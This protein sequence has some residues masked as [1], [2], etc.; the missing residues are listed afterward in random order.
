MYIDEFYSKR[1]LFITG[2]TGFLGKSLIEKLLRDCPGIKTMYMLIRPK[3]GKTAMERLVDYKNDPVFARLRR[4]QPSVLDK[5]VPIVG[6]CS[7]I[8]LGISQEDLN[9]LKNVSIIF[10][11]AAFVKFDNDLR[12]SILMNT[13]GTYELVKIAQTLKHLIAFIHCSTAYIY[14]FGHEIEE[15][16]YKLPTDWRTAIKLAET[17]DVETLEILRLKYTGFFPNPY[18]F[19]KNLAEQIIAD[20]SDVLPMTIL[21]PV[22][23]APAYMEPE[24]GY[25]DN[26]NGP[27]GI[28]AAVSLGVSQ[29]AY[30]NP[31]LNL[32]LIPVDLVTS[33]TIGSGFRCGMETLS[34]PKSSP[35]KLRIQT[36]A[37]GKMYDFTIQ[38]STK[39]IVELVKKNP[40]QNAVWAPSPRMTTNMYWYLIWLFLVHI[41]MAIIYDLI[42]VLAKRKPIL[43]KTTRRIIYTVRTLGKFS[44]KY[45]EFHNEGMWDLYYATMENDRDHRFYHVDAMNMDFH[46]IFDG[47]LKGLKKFILKE[48]EEATPAT[49]RRFQ[50]LLMAD[51]I[52]KIILFVVCV[53]WAWKWVHSFV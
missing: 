27:M 16:I 19:T 37:P 34:K 12:S 40:I 2:G 33:L 52:I 39:K 38:Q 26:L 29:M 25:F 10:H 18:S 17:Y 22:V 49:R 8:G 50:M 43:L 48:P 21:R 1:E 4:D 41:P 36:F 7:E 11:E 32:S 24:P 9:R 45:F 53:K 44:K 14:P 28:L 51:Q 42:F 13:R 31:D 20:H 46:H 23:V 3:R 6:E 47:T 35:L 30:V 5:I 15:K